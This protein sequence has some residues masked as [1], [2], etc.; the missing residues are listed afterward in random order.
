MYLKISFAFKLLF[1][2]ERNVNL[3]GCLPQQINM[4]QDVQTSN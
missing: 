2:K 3:V 1:L 4:Y